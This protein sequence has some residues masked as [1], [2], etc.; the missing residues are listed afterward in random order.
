MVENIDPK[1]QELMQ[2]AQDVLR[3]FLSQDINTL[4]ALTQ[5]T[6]KT[7]DNNIRQLEDKIDPVWEFN[8]FVSA[9]IMSYMYDPAT[10][11]L[12][13]VII[14]FRCADGH[15]QYRR[16]NFLAEFASWYVN[17]ISMLWNSPQPPQP[18]QLP[19]Y[20]V[21]YIKKEDIQ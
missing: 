11:F 12:V 3:A 20:F 16:F 18:P 17:P 6:W 8:N 9:E 13:A 2:I 21:P 19:E 10:P 4:W 5:P 14:E 7:F 15:K 1:K